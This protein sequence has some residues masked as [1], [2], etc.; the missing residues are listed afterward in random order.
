LTRRSGIARIVG[1]DVNEGFGY[2]KVNNAAFGA[3]I[4]GIYPNIDFVKIDLTSKR[5]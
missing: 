4:E 2:Q 5:D 3:Q 1:A